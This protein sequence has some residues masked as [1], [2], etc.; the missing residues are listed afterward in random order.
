MR[1]FDEIFKFKWQKNKFSENPLNQASNVVRVKH[2]DEAPNLPNTSLKGL[3]QAKVLSAEPQ[4][5]TANSHHPDRKYQTVQ[6]LK[7]EDE[8]KQG[9]ISS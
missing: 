4:F 3:T 5:Q 6:N 2:E 1:S 9:R 8:W 7:N